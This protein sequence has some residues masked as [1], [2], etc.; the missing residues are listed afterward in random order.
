M[1]IFLKPIRNIFATIP[2][3]FLQTPARITMCY[4][5]LN[6]SSYMHLG[7]SGPSRGGAL[8][9]ISDLCKK[10]F[11]LCVHTLN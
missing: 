9:K 5:I 3:V 1:K 11:S 10:E 7:E 8:L 4:R 2:Q 6:P